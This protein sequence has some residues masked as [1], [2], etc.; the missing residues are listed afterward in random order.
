MLKR[1]QMAF[2]SILAIAFMALGTSAH[3]SSNALKPGDVLAQEGDSG[4]WHVVRVLEVDTWPDGTK[5]AHCLTYEDTESK[6]TLDS[7]QS[8]TVRIWHAPIAEESFRTEWDLIGNSKISRNELKGFLEYLKINDFPRYIKVSGTDA[9]KLVRQANQHY[10]R[11]NSLAEQGEKSSAIDEYGLAINIFPLFYE[12]I[13]N[14]AFTYMELGDYQSALR[15]FENSLEV[16]PEGVT[17]FFSKGE[18]LLKLGR[19]LEAREVFSSGIKKFPAHS[20]M[21]SKYLDLANSER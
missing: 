12:A 15:D 20:A 3:S 17:A 19:L 11:A 21:F 13:D 8:L 10:Q 4:K 14:R 2:R 5:T 7:I 16:Y 18:C 6:P 1:T 9:K